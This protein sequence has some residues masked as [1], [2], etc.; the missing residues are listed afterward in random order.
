ME[1]NEPIKCCYP[2]FLMFI[3]ELQGQRVDC[4]VVIKRVTR[5]IT[6]SLLRGRSG[7]LFIYAGSTS[8]TGPRN[9]SDA[10]RRFRRGLNGGRCGRLGNGEDEIG[11]TLVYPVRSLVEGG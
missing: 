6:L 3:E 9:G 2:G 5:D 1:H 10:R 8:S 7:I 4:S 11:E